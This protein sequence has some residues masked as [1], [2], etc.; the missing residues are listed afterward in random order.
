VIRTETIFQEAE[1]SAFIELTELRSPSWLLRPLDPRIVSE[2]QRSIANVGLL[3]PIVVRKCNS[4]YE[5]VFGNHRLEACKRLRLQ[6]VLAIIRQFSDEEAFLARLSENLI[7]NS[8]IDPIEEAKGYR[9]L[10]DKRWTIN[11]IGRKLGKSDSYVSERLGLLER[12]SEKISRDVSKGC[13][14]PSHA[15]IISRIRDPTIQNEVAEL[16]KVKRLSVRSL[17]NIL[18]GA[19]P[20]VQIQL[21]ELSKPSNT[22]GLEIPMEFLRALGASKGQQ[23]LVYVSGHKL[24]IENVRAPRGRARTMSKTPMVSEILI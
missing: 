9:A 21:S 11:A 12:L 5:V 3:Q 7:R 16:V 14:T 2:L 10:V 24:I 18:K 23:L 19:P 6:R 15:E 13:L 20:P 22:Y 4:G 17:E 1:P 8:Y